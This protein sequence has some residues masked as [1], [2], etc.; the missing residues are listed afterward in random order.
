ML[1]RRKV[2]TTR[3]RLRQP[4]QIE[5]EQSMDDNEI[6]E[7]N[8]ETTTFADLSIGRPLTELLFTTRSPKTFILS[9]KILPKSR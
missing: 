1:K 8:V 5:D 4:N 9:D 3:F 6:D 7:D 2:K